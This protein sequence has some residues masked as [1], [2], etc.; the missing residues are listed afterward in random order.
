MQLEEL[1][2]NWVHLVTSTEDT[3]PR[4]T[5]AS[6]VVVTPGGALGNPIFCSQCWYT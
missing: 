2:M 4:V 6:R 1:L 5:I 3:S